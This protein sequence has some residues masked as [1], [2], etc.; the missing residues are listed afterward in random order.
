MA[1]VLAV[2]GASLMTSAASR[3]EGSEWLWGAARPNPPL[4]EAPRGNIQSSAAH[5]HFFQ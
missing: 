4:P 2:E 3:T 5:F 1:A